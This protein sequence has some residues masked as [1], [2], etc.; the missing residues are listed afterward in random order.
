MHQA[1]QPVAF[2]D[3]GLGG[4]SVLRAAV[5]ALPHENFIY[6]GDSANAPYGTK[7]PEEIARLSG[8]VMEKVLAMGAKAVV[9]ACNTATGMAVDGLRRKY[10]EL[11]IIGVEPAVKPAAEAFPGGRILVLATPMCLQ[12][13]RFRELHRRFSGDAEIVPVPCGGLMEFVE[14]GEL[15]GERLHT[16]LRQLLEPHLH[17][18]VDAAV[19]G[20]THY[21]FLRG[22]IAEVLGDTTAIIDGNAGITAQLRR[23]LEEQG[24]L[25]PSSEPGAV[26]F[27]NSLG[28]EGI[29]IRSRALLALPE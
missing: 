16:W 17:K 5:R 24:L 11:T 10:P 6:Y 12:G 2:F 28:D 29:L 18:K 3:S 21:P 8:S 4:I 7:P 22:A 19:L 1:Q 15:E 26:T 13:Q 9:I 20:C 27:Y 23:R 14:R 25:N